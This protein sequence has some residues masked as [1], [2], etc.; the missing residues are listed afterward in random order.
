MKFPIAKRAVAQSVAMA[1][2]GGSA[3]VVSSQASANDIYSGP[4][5]TA[6]NNADPGEVIGGRDGLFNPITV[7]NAAGE[8]EVTVSGYVRASFIYDSEGDLGDSFVVSSIPTVGDDGDPHFRA[9]ARQS[10]L[11]VR[12]STE[13]EGGST[14][15]THI[16][17]DFFGAGGNESFSNSTAFR[18]RHAY[19]TVGGWTFGQTWTNFMDFVAYPGTV[20]FFGPAGKSFVRQAQIR[21]TFDNGLAFSI[22]N[23]ETDGFDAGGGR[24][25]ESRGGIGEDNAPDF[26]AAWR[27]G[28]GGIGG[29]YEFA[30]IV[31]TLGVGGEV[32]DNVGGVGFLAA[33]AWDLG[34]GTLAASVVTGSGI[35]RYIINGFANEVFVD[36]TGD[37]EAI[38][39]T[40][41]SVS[42]NHKW[43]GSATSLIALGG[44]VNN[45]DDG[46]NNG[47]DNL[48]TLHVNYQWDTSSGVSYGVEGIVGNVEDSNGETGTATRLAFG[49]QFNF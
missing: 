16:E 5:T 36:E 23:S 21:Y 13:L 22:E 44:F 18:L 7:R 29:N 32:D 20:D 38:T 8:T 1:L 28:P 12:S 14:V 35:G 49:A 15:K 10:R 39:A 42:Y 43:S 34:T 11:R 9:H 24:L 37:L 26:T 6:T 19:L 30:G 27:G 40:G 46:G 45:D 33:G 41:Y 4:G 2:V 3:V 47:I 17:G 48:Q 25:G 31:R